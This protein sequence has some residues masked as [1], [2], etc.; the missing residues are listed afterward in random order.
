MSAM[1]WPKQC[2]NRPVPELHRSDRSRDLPGELGTSNAASAAAGIVLCSASPPVSRFRA[3]AE[4]QDHQ[5]V[6]VA[7]QLCSRGT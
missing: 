2:D 3:Q 4:N 5:H 7:I 1:V 6:L